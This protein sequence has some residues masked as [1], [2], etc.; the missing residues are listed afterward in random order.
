MK[1]LTV[2]KLIGLAWMVSLVMVAGIDMFRSVPSGLVTSDYNSFGEMYPEIV[3]YVLMFPAVI[4]VALD[5]VKYVAHNDNNMTA[6]YGE[7]TL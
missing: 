6:S 3:M 2:Y 5:F 1:L 4:M 7:V